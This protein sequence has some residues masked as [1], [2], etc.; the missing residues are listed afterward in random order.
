MIQRKQLAAPRDG[1][2]QS[3]DPPHLEDQHSMSEPSPVVLRSPDLHAKGGAAPADDRCS[4]C[5]MAVLVA[6]G[7]VLGCGLTL[8]FAV[9]ASCGVP[10]SAAPWGLPKHLETARV[11]I[12]GAPVA[13]A[14]P[15]IVLLGDSI[16]AKAFDA[17]GGQSWA[18][19]MQSWYGA[20]ADVISRGLP[21][22]NTRWVAARMTQLFPTSVLPPA[23]VVVCFGANDAAVETL[24][25]TQHVPIPEFK[26]NLLSIIEHI[27]SLSENT[28]V[29]VLTPPPVDEGALGQTLRGGARRCG[30]TS[31]LVA[32][33]D[34]AEHA[35]ACAR[36]NANPTGLPDRLLTQTKIYATASLAVASEAGVAALDIWNA[37]KP[38]TTLSDGFHLNS[39]GHRALL[40]AI[41]VKIRR[42]YPSMIPS[43]M[44]QDPLAPQWD[45]LVGVVADGPSPLSPLAAGNEG[46]RFEASL[47]TLGEETMTEIGCT[48]QAKLV[49]DALAVVQVSGKDCPDAPLH[50]PET[51]GQ[52]TI[53]E[54][55]SRGE[56]EE[57][58]EHAVNLGVAL[59][60]ILLLAALILGHSLE[61]RHIEA[62]HEAGGALLIGIAGGAVLRLTGGEGSGPV[63]VT[64]ATVLG[65]A[66]FDE[67]FFF[68]VLLP[69]IILEAG[70]NM[71]RRKFFQNIGAICMFAFVGT[72]ISTAIIAAILWT[73][74]VAAT[75]DGEGFTPLEA[76]IFGSLIS[77]TDPVTVL[78]IFGSQGADRDLYSLV[79]GESVLNDAV[80][81]VL[82]QT[83]DSFNPRHCAH[84]SPA[85]CEM[86]ISTVVKAGGSAFKILFGSIFVGTA[87]A[88]ASAY[89]LKHRGLYR[90]ADL[91]FQTEIL[92]VVLFP[93]IAWML[94]EA[95]HLSGIVSILFCGIVMAHYTTHNLHPDSLA[96]SRKFFKVLAFGCE[97]FVFVYMGLAL[98][99]FRQDFAHWP[100]YIVG[101]LAMLG[102]RAAN[103]YPIACCVN[104][105]RRTGRHIPV[106][107]QHICWFSGLRGAIAFALALKARMDYDTRDA[108][109]TPGAGR[110][111]FTMTLATVLFTGT[112]VV[113]PCTH[114]GLIAAATLHHYYP[115]YV[116]FP[117]RMK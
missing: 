65:V 12:G 96:F 87:M 23:L 5:R 90:R 82:Y 91:F 6:F 28:L 88:F 57:G 41:Q 27:R 36:F 80:A 4:G 117:E 31:G 92:V 15:T 104:R 43:D 33:N 108:N 18:G 109:G 110:A 60:L 112:R 14:R 32:E 22:Y 94:A 24:S 46:N 113:L 11:A 59:V 13:P 54:L 9:A 93:Y 76:L 97:T 56:S 74:G 17:E 3:V 29:L 67:R 81:I 26:K 61:I 103:V 66:R 52:G 105:Y 16:A 51:T 116:P 47:S 34:A 71:Q 30:L 49:A 7:I 44:P 101:V 50:T 84:E 69:P 63:A 115:L 2:F 53:V 10:A 37:L 79:F 95:A 19:G 40:E 64:H 83:F 58:N 86:S 39:D 114:T 35:L 106:G 98:F 102:A 77:A 107:F 38:E 85:N 70:Y 1:S 75:P 78:A 48:E 55:E 21:G 25:P 73:S 89:L 100:T 72:L 68:F 42:S 62:L 8:R 20:K 45:T 111:I 99:S